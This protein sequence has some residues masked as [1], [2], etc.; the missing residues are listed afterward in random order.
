MFTFLTVFK[1][2]EQNPRSSVSILVFFGF[3]LELNS[4]DFPLRNIL[5]VSC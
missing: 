4:L 1:L 3:D 5:S 2:C